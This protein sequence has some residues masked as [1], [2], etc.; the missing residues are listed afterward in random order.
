M[1]REYLHDYV[2]AMLVEMTVALR[3]ELDAKIAAAIEAHQQKTAV[4][5]LAE[6]VDALRAELKQTR[7]TLRARWLICR[8]PC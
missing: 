5:K 8:I 3:A 7:S 4:T 2:R 6:T 1:Q